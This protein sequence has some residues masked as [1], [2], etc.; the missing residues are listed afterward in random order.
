MLLRFDSTVCQLKV[1][2]R[3][4]VDSTTEIFIEEPRSLPVYNGKGVGSFSSRTATVE[5]QRAQGAK[6]ERK[7][8]DQLKE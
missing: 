1:P 5:L 6:E 3:S 8:L 7:T 4:V 2:W